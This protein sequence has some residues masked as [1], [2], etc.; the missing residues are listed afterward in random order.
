[1]QLSVCSWPLSHLVC[2]SDPEN[3]NIFKQLIKKPGC[4][5]QT[6]TCGMALVYW[7][8]SRGLDE[9]LLCCV[10]SSLVEAARGYS[11]VSVPRL[12]TVAASLGAERG[13]WDVASL[14]AA[15]GPWSTGSIAV[16]RG[17]SCPAACAVPPDQGWNPCLTHCQVD[18]LPPSH[19]G[20][21]QLPF[22]HTSLEV[23]GN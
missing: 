5:R 12:L 13:L 19:R 16:V 21:P 7:V 11:L 3:S 17:L 6:C 23:I 9:R 20:S 4:R 22:C 15:P 1:M 18:A 10:N 2:Q 8:R 14:V